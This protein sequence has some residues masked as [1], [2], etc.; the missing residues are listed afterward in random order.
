[1]VPVR[2]RVGLVSVMVPLSGGVEL[3]SLIVSGS[4]GQDLVSRAVKLPMHTTSKEKG[5]CPCKTPNFSHPHP[6]TVLTTAKKCLHG[7]RFLNQSLQ[8][9]EGIVESEPKESW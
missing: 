2:E 7:G 9:Q 8:V 6:C 1:M 3:L 5:G 4:G